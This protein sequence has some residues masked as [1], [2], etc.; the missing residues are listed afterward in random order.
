V[1]SVTRDVICQIY[2]T[3]FSTNISLLISNT[4]NASNSFDV[5]EGEGLNV[6]GTKF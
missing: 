6:S 2:P 4:A 1:G 3:E 5:Y